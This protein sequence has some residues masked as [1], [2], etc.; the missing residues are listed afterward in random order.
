M[1]KFK[2]VCICY[3][4]SLDVNN[5]LELKALSNKKKENIWAVV[6]CVKTFI[7]SCNIAINQE[8]DTMEDKSGDI[9]KNSANNT[10][11]ES[12]VG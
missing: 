2:S 3:I 10:D 4:T 5:F 6:K 1:L 12:R 11:I 9:L 7:V 8:G